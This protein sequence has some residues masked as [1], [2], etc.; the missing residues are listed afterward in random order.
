M[1]EGSQAELVLPRSG[2]ARVVPPRQLLRSPG[3]LAVRVP[4]LY[5]RSSL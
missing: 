4:P 3:S 2:E 1:A 5:P